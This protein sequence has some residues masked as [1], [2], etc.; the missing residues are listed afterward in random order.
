MYYIVLYCITL[1]YIILYYIVLY[2]IVLYCIVLY[3]I[4]LCCIVLY[5]IVLYCI[6]F[7]YIIFI[8]YLYYIISYHIISYHIMLC[9]GI[10]YY[11]KLYYFI[12]SYIT[13]HYITLHYITLHY[14]ILYYVM[15]CYAMLY[16]IILKCN[17]EALPTSTLS[18]PLFPLGCSTSTSKA[19][20]S[21]S[22]TVNHWDPC[23]YVN[24]STVHSSSLPIVVILPWLPWL[25]IDRRSEPASL[26]SITGILLQEDESSG[27]SWCSTSQYLQSVYSTGIKLIHFFMFST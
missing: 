17:S 16:Y 15:L 5:C 7:Y 18:T 13:L 26:R 19:L 23:R 8:L 27:V 10:L 25:Q 24:S 21:S 6:V 11:I 14:I 2:C 3:Y 9:Y 1:Y 12:L 20:L 4:I 22:V